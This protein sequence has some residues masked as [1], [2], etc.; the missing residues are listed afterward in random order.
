MTLKVDMEVHIFFF[1]CEAMMMMTIISVLMGPTV[2]LELR[3]PATA[4]AQYV[5]MLLIFL[6]ESKLFQGADLSSI[7]LSFYSQPCS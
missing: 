2:S 7:C 1:K 5:I 4:V 3:N 6:N